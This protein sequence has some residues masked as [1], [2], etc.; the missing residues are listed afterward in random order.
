MGLLGSRERGAG[1][2]PPGQAGVRR[3]EQRNWGE[4]H[5]A[6]LVPPG[7]RCAP[8]CAGRAAPAGEPRPACPLA[9]NPTRIPAD[10]QTANPSP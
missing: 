3:A 8:L 6:T 4:T 2:C 7:A 1:P 9:P 10:L 5:P